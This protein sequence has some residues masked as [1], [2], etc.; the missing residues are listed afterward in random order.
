[1]KFET[2]RL[3]IRH[4]NMDDAADIFRNYAQD[5]EVT[6]YLTWKPHKELK[7]TQRWIQY[8][9]ENANTKSSLVF[10]LYSKEATEAIGMID[11]RLEGFKAHFGYVL[12]R[13]YW[14][15]GLMTEAMQPLIEYFNENPNIYRLW[16]AH[17]I[18]NEASGK[19]MLKLGMRCEGVMSGKLIYPNIS[20]EP[21]DSTYYSLDCRRYI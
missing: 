19:V 20:S 15:Q 7:E 14:N 16:A 4:P 3:I 1:M 9:I 6:K 18:E 11:F 8:C 21:R 17:D 13:R 12:A 5:S 2:N 10:V